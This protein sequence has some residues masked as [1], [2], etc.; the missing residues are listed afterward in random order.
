MKKITLTTL[1]LVFGLTISVLTSTA[2]EQLQP[3][4]QLST[5][6]G[7]FADIK[8]FSLTKIG[9]EATATQPQAK[10]TMANCT[11]KINYVGNTQGQYYTPL[12][13]NTLSASQWVYGLFQ[14]YPNY[15]GQVLGVELKA[16][17]YNAANNPKINVAI[18]G[19]TS[20]WWPDESNQQ[21]PTATFTI[22]STSVSTY[23]VP[24]S[25][26]IPVSDGF[27]IGIWAQAQDSAKIPLGPVMPSSNPI[28]TYIYNSSGNMY[29]IDYWYGINAN[30]LLKPIVTTS[31]NPQW[32]TAKTSTGCGIPAVYE[33]TNTTNSDPSYVGNAVINPLGVSTSLDYGD[34]SSV[35]NN[36]SGV[37]TH[38]YTTLGSYTAAYTKTYQGWTNTCTE[39]KTLAVEVNYPQPSFTYNTN[40][41]TVEFTNTSQNLNNF[42]W[43]FGDLSTSNQ[44]NP[45]H[46]F[47]SPGTYVV[48]L[49]AVAP[50]GTVFIAQS[51]V[52][53]PVSIKEQSVLENN[54]ALFPNP[55]ANVLHVNNQYESEL[56]SEIK[57]YNSTGELVKTT[58]T[59]L[60]VGTTDI[61]VST[62]SQGFY[63]IKIKVK[64]GELVKSFVKE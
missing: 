5:E 63:F 30:L 31:V 17:K 3:M 22:T 53:S 37:K 4:T 52:V 44:N 7:H 12:G 9:E 45:T 40:G 38:S 29:D 20:S 13:S 24:F 34:G 6:K 51:V 19:L 59:Q 47:S 54:L 11:D 35:V 21:F 27:A 43:N 1:A 57:I 62:L 16:Y 50:C 56:N 26:A 23:S 36:F 55:A 48:E 2:Q 41:L 8:K 33:F 39:T 49:T 10:V 64:E 18:F 14:V 60:H 32:L 46:T 15:T 25:S 61:D 58:N 42:S 28:Y